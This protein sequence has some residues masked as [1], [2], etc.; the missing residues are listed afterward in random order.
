LKT[1][2]RPSSAAATAL[3]ATHLG[4]KVVFVD[5]LPETLCLDPSRVEAAIT[6]RTKAIVPV[7]LYGFPART[8]ELEAICAKRGIVLI[9]DCAQAVGTKDSGGKIAGTRG[10]VGCFSFYPTKNLGAFGDAG[11]MCTN[12]AEIAAKLRKLRNYGQRVR[13]DHELAG[14]NSR[15]DE[16]HAAIL[17]EKLKPLERW[18][19]RRE[20]IA[21]K[22]DAGLTDVWKLP[23]AGS[24]RAV[25]HLYPIQLENRD[26]LLAKM[27]TAGIEGGVHYPTLIPEQECYRVTGTQDASKSWPV[28]FAAT[29]RL[30][31]LPINPYTT[32]EEV[33]TIID[34][35][36]RPL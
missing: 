6:S 24:G 17:R 1:S 30:V 7:H 29:R 14:Y 35:V 19:K 5:V 31:S 34:C 25:Y 9:E 13:Y 28:A 18:T 4:A 33:A 26:G 16:L 12:D 27:K 8:I 3:A 15:L 23:S 11:F 32:D 22:F 10:I 36:K 2:S 21:R 20:E